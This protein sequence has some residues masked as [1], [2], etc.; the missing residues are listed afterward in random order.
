MSCTT[1]FQ[2]RNI[3]SRELLTRKLGT[4]VS[5]HHRLDWRVAKHFAHGLYAHR[6]PLR[7]ICPKLLQRRSFSSTHVDGCRIRVDRVTVDNAVALL[8]SPTTIMP[9][10]SAEVADLRDPSADML[11]SS[12]PAAASAR[13]C[14]FM[15][16]RD[17][18]MWLRASV[19]RP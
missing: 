1:R 11:Q 9:D 8:F 10:V 2:R 6:R 14:P 4:R 3:T 19:L 16:R 18:S 17:S 15:R 13:I 7:S 12:S 5:Q